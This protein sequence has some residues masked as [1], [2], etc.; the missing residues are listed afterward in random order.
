VS[1]FSR[2]APRV[3]LVVPH[4]FTARLF[5]RSSLL[6]ELVRRAEHVGIY[7]P[8]ASLG[9]LR[10][11]LDG[12]A[13]SFHRLIGEESRL[14]V[15]ANFIRLLVADWELTATRRIREQEEWLGK[16][17]RRPLWP[18]HA[19]LGRFSGPR[20]AWYALENRLLP[21]GF[22]ADSFRALQPDVVVTATP[23]V[24]TSDIRLIRRARAEGIPTVTFVQGWDNL[25]SKTI[26][27]ARPDELIVWNE[28]MRGEAGALHGFDRER[29][30]VTGAPHLDPY[31]TRDGWTSRADFLRSIG[32]DPDKRIILYGTSPKRYFTDSLEVVK[33]LADAHAAG[34]FGADTQVVVRVHPQVVQGPDAEDLGRYEP[35][36]GRVHL[37]V[38]RA[39][40]KLVADYTPSGI[41][42]AGQLIEAAAVTVNVASSFTI[43]ACIFDRPVVNVCFDAAPTPYLKS[44][45]RQYDTDHYAFVV[46]SGAVRMADSPRMLIDEVK[47]YLA[48][49]ALERAN[50][51]RLVGELCYRVDGRSGARVAE[52]IAEIG[53]RRS[54]QRAGREALAGAR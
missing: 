49:P 28:R 32:V 2:L 46:G 8:A 45:R 42:H 34:E 35:F 27:G 20:R 22:H 43:D 3:A 40:S 17:W 5:L 38:P 41:R 30:A 29:V 19:R 48:D 6:P 7:A 13:F 47:R 52:R 26:V 23:G 24:V 51:A 14:D 1:L 9:A 53:A 15:M 11:D 16:P 44:V 31:A 37:D 39:D 36:R 21:D 4:G 18:L 12:P 10:R 50:R 25:T 54:R 33:L